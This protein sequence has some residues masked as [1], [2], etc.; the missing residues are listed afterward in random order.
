MEG[1]KYK[2][3]WH[4]S[5]VYLLDEQGNIIKEIKLEV[6]KGKVF[7]SYDNK[8]EDG[9]SFS[10]PDKTEVNTTS[11]FHLNYDVSSQDGRN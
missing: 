1:G 10:I 2:I 9:K 3:D 4:N 11:I 6:Q 5:K 8:N 7:K